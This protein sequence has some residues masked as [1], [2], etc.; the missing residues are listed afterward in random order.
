MII[1]HAGENIKLY[2]I[3]LW[4]ENHQQLTC[5]HNLGCLLEHWQRLTFIL[6]QSIWSMDTLKVHQQCLAILSSGELSFKENLIFK[7]VLIINTVGNLTLN[8]ET[9]EFVT[10]RLTF[11]G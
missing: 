9:C 5:F 7:N 10:S 2:F 6:K 4:R 11:L 8:E 1:V 3:I